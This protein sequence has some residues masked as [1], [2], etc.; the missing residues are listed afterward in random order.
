MI[1]WG[2]IG[3]GAICRT[4]AQ[5]VGSLERQGV[6]TRLAAVA[7]RSR[8]GADGFARWHAAEVPGAG[9][10][11]AHASYEALFA[12]PEIDAVYV[13]TPHPAHA[14]NA[15]AAL[16]A[17]KAVLCEKPLT[18]NA[19]EAGELVAEA[20]G[21]RRFL[22]EAMWTRFLPATLRVREW[23]AAGEIGEVRLLQA[24]FG[25]PVA[26]NPDGRLLN[27]ALG[28]GALLDIG[29]Y[30][31]SYAAMLFGTAP[32]SIQS[33]VHIGETGVDEQASILLHYPGGAQAQ[34][35]CSLRALVGSGAEIYGTTGSITLP[36]F[37]GP[38]EATLHR[39][40]REPL[41]FESPLPH[42]HNGYEPMLREVLRCLAAGEIESPVMTHRESLEIMGMIDAIRKEWPLR[43]EADEG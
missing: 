21:R 43:Y 2:F 7:S 19:R 36:Q 42:G 24:R 8:E 30:P 11:T 34:L 22:M 41:R 31:V 10:L 38:A 32:L 15:L 14:A 9:K 29:I 40:E 39:Q 1:R 20:Q 37:F 12:D 17:G 25:F 4:L 18:M 6:A 26:R 16:R 3:T 35:T 5:A 23:I 28:G 13:G 33:A 27:K